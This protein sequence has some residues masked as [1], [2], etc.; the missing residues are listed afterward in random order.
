MDNIYQGNPPIIAVLKSAITEKISID[1][2]EGMCT[3]NPQLYMPH[4]SFLYKILKIKLYTSLS[5]ER[6]TSGA[7]TVI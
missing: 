1:H 5:T 2:T 7:G 3:R 4:F 6:Q